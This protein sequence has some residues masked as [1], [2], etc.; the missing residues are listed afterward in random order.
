M[1]EKIFYHGL[2]IKYGVV[3]I[4]FVM[5]FDVCN[6]SV[7]TFFSFKYVFLKKEIKNQK[8]ITTALAKICELGSQS[9]TLNYLRAGLKCCRCYGS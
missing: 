1:D 5:Q 8:T 9:V 7:E 2:F 3:W 4:V 6:E